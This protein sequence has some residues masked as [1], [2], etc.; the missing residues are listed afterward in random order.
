MYIIFDDRNILIFNN[1]A[2]E[3]CCFKRRDNIDKWAVFS[4]SNQA[5][6]GHNISG[7]FRWHYRFIIGAKLNQESFGI[8]SCWYHLNKSIIKCYYY[9]FPP[10]KNGYVAF[11][12]LK[13]ICCNIEQIFNYRSLAL[14]KLSYERPYRC[15]LLPYQWMFMA[16]LSNAF[17]VAEASNG[18]LFLFW[19]KATPLSLIDFIIVPFSSVEILKIYFDISLMLHIALLY[20]ILAFWIHVW[21]LYLQYLFLIFDID[22]DFIGLL[23]LIDDNRYK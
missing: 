23:Y 12:H 19:W 5:Y 2:I 3:W 20:E 18:K 1:W 22:I 14:I 10:F 15:M 9:L 16:Y 8:S 11:R 17:K 4:L 7:N 21:L 6:F 13:I